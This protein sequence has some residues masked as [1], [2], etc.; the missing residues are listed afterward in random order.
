[1]E[2]KVELTIEIHSREIRFQKLKF[3]AIVIV[4]VS[5]MAD[6]TFD[7]HFIYFISFLALYLKVAGTKLFLSVWEWSQR[8]TPC[9]ECPIYFKPFFWFKPPD[10]WFFLSALVSYKYRHTSFMIYVDCDTGLESLDYQLV[11]VMECFISQ[12]NESFCPLHTKKFY[13]NLPLAIQFI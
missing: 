11:S 1:M 8:L 3:L 13:N 9:W 12:I 6:R 4:L 2:N 7:K 10:L 5:Q